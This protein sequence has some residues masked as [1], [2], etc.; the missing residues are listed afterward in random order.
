MWRQERSGQNKDPSARKKKKGE[1]RVVTETHRSRVEKDLI[2]TAWVTKEI[3]GKG[4]T[5]P[6]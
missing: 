3:I 6:G 4:E 1:P 2:K 5:K